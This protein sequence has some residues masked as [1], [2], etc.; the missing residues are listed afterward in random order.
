MATM[1]G[2]KCWYGNGC[3]CCNGARP[4]R[5]EKRREEREWRRD[6]DVT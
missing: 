6:Q 3:S 5:V 1:L 2:R 4:K